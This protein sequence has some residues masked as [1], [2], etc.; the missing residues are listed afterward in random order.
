MAL[1]NLTIFIRCEAMLSFGANSG[2]TLRSKNGVHAFGYNSAECVP[3]W[4][5]FGEL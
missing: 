2:F 3:I 4:L 1:A 5:R